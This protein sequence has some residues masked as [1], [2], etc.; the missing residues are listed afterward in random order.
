MDMR[1]YFILFFLLQVL[2]SK[3]QDTTLLCHQEDVSILSLDNINTKSIEFSPAFYHNGIVFVQARE[4]NKFLDP[5][6]GKAYFD[7]MYADKGTDGSVLKPVS[8][9]PNI[10]TQYHEGPCTFNADGTE[11]FFT[12]SATTDT[13]VITGKKENKQ[14]KIYTATKGLE[15]WENLTALPFT[16][17]QGIVQHPALSSDGQFLVF[18]SNM[19]G[20]HGG[21]DLYITN[22]LKGEWSTPVN[23][24]DVINTS[25]N[26]AFPFWQANG[27]LIFAS[28]GHKGLG[29]YDLFA[30]GWNGI[31]AFKGLQHLESPFNSDHD[32]LG[33]I[34]SADGKSGYFSS[35]RK[36]T[37]GKDD[38]YNWS[39]PE[40]IICLPIPVKSNTREILVRNETRIPLDNAYVW[41]IPMGNEGPTLY[42]EKFNT[43]L[44]PKADQQ[45][46]FYLKWGVTDTLSIATAN[47]ISKTDGIASYTT[48]PK[49]TYIL[50]VQHEGYTPYVSVFSEDMIP[51]EVLLKPIPVASTACLNTRFMVY[52]E[53]GKEILNGARVEL[54][55]NCLKEPLQFYTN[56]NGLARHCLPEHCSVKAL[57]SQEGYAPHTFTFTPNEEDELWSVYLKSGDQ[58]TAP[59]APIASGTV[60]VLDN[61]YYDFNK[62]EIRKSDAGEL[63]GL[64]RILKQYPDLKI[65]LTSHTDTR[66]TAEYNLELSRR[67]SESSKSYLVSLGIDPKRITTK[68]A[69]ESQPRNQCVDGVECTEEEHQYNRRTEVRITNPA[70]GMEVKYKSPE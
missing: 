11:M 16:S 50:V 31:D 52:N 61:I 58:L 7:L 23:L 41:L 56:E 60:I 24:G 1:L 53:N 54:T 6:T 36:P 39:S 45:G 44:L 19:S 59:P 17:D 3:S 43:E 29:G 13:T 67:R 26:E 18:A 8:F 33:L 51:R 15:D 35:D 70:Q 64:A 57:I 10:R 28:E 63:V 37:Q 69:G 22:R 32:D 30:T 49:S 68:A 42:K 48:D 5:K 62:S 14:I 40:S 55:G 66:G 4:N 65:E 34:I 25:A 46:E 47:A 38:I 9:S 27:I 12:R 20:G 2:V 21:T